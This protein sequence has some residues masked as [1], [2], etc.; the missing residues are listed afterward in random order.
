MKKQ[1]RKTWRHEVIFDRNIYNIILVHVARTWERLRLNQPHQEMPLDNIESA[2]ELQIIAD[3]IIETD[4]VQEFLSNRD[5]DVWDKFGDGCSDVY[6][7]RVGA[8]YIT[9]N[10]L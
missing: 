2:E 6:I 4:L 1:F 3:F 7:E 8:E 5:G 10:Y 9:E